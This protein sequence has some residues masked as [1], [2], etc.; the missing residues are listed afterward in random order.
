MEPTE[1]VKRF[2]FPNPPEHIPSW[3]LKEAEPW[4]GLG[5]FE[6]LVKAEKETGRTLELQEV[7]LPSTLWGLHV[8][9]GNRA[10]I[11]VNRNL[12]SIWKRFALFHELYHLLRHKRGEAF[13]SATATPLSSFEF[14]ADMFAWAA[15]RPDWVGE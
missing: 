13:W 8:A 1:T 12:P 9:R 11:Y 5:E 4:V 2:D 7:V 15:I 3:A 14:Q 10:R 6:I